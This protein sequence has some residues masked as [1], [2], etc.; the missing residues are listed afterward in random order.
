MGA[1]AKQARTHNGNV[2]SVC[3]ITNY[4]HANVESRK[5]SG[6]KSCSI[7]AMR[8]FCNNR[9][10]WKKNVKDISFISSIEFST[11]QVQAA[12]LFICVNGN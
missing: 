6:R 10:V 8:I 12:A 7:A 3:I 9:V 2:F 4:E 11:R 1:N 5:N